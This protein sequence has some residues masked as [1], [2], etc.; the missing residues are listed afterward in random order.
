MAVITECFDNCL[1]VQTSQE[2]FQKKI[3]G[4]PG[5]PVRRRLL[6]QVVPASCSFIEAEDQ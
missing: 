4:M 5:F 3:G 2:S 1:I 6:F